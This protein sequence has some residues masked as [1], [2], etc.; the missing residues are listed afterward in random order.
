MTRE[1]SPV[2]D[3][4]DYTKLLH[5]PVYSFANP[6]SALFLNGVPFSGKSTI[7][8]LITSVIGGCVVQSMD[9]IRLL[10]QEV[11]SL[12]PSDQRDPFV[13]LGSCDS[14]KLVGDGSYSRESLIAGFNRYANAVASLLDKVVPELQPQGSQHVLFEGVQLIPNTVSRFLNENRRL[15]IIRSSESRLK[16]NLAQRLGNDQELLERYSPERLLILQD[17]IIRQAGELPAGQFFLVDNSG[18]YLE[19]TARIIRYLV[20]EGIIQ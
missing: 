19:S 7:S 16:D 12:K 11:D 10:A 20:T 6:D 14:F 18:D 8:P 13:A 15:I 17:E 4:S 9:I 2:S 1:V 3:M 5:H